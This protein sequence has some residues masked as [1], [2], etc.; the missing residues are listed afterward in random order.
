MLKA[1]VVSAIQNLFTE[2]VKSLAK[3]IR[4][5]IYLLFKMKNC[6]LQ[7]AR[8]LII[9]YIIL[10][11]SERDTG[12]NPSHRGHSYQLVCYNFSSTKRCFDIRMLYD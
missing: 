6:F 3:V 2:P 9:A 8:G 10:L 12:H 5:L 11:P 4:L 7:C 1:S